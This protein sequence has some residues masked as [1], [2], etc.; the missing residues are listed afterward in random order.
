MTDSTGQAADRFWTRLRRR[1][2]VQWG[3]AY[4]A[5]AWTLL[6]GLEYAI[7]TF[8]WKEQIRQLATLVAVLGLPVVIVIAWYHGDRGN[9][10]VKSTELVIVAVLFLLSGIVLWRYEPVE[11]DARGVAGK[12]DPAPSAAPTA[13]AAASVAVLP[14]AAL[15]SGE[16]DAYFADGLTDEII[17]ALSALPDVLVTAR[18]S[19]FH[20]KGKDVPV[21]EIARTLGVAHVVEGSIRR[22]GDRA[23]ITAQLIRAADG[24]HLWAETY[25]YTAG[26]DFAVQTQIA[27]SVAGALGVL[28]DERRR[29][30]MKAAGVRDVQAFVAFQR[31]VQ[32]FRRA[33]NEGPML[34]VLEQANAEFEVALARKPD[35]AQAHFYHADLYAHFLIDH[36]PGKGSGVT[37]A[38]GIGVTEAARMLTDDISKAYRYEHDPSQRQVIQVLWTTVTS[39]WRH[40]EEQIVQA[41]EGWDNCRHGLWVDQTA[42]L[43]GYGEQAL[44]QELRRSRCDPLGETWNREAITAVWTGRPLDGMKYADDLERRRGPGRDV[45]YSRIVALLSLGR[46]DGA[47]TLYLAGGLDAPDVPP[48]MS[49]LALQIPAAAGRAEKWEEL[50]PT[51]ERD[52]TR[53]LVGAAVFGDRATANRTAGEIDSLV[54]GPTILLRV[55]DRCGCGSPFDLESTPNLAGLLREGGLPWA[56][57]TPIRFPLK[58]W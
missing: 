27:E 41:Y 18:T 9:Q 10:R 21:P 43:F 44:A 20:F 19:A 30:L 58:N 32:L 47:E 29:G 52:P 11:T 50:R 15:S 26:E 24:F 45:D 42:I 53:L 46:L 31:G 6:Q 5:T 7:E 22:S 39:D 37:L 33:H 28:L 48:F 34:P 8:H 14:F 16:D 1:K 55:T 40:L 17:N 35:F 51:I 23:R 3:L 4:A 49:L 2:V 54:L 13:V 57:P 56:P 12:S 38:G 25:N 36:A